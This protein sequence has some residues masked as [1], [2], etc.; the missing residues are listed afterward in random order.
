MNH[1]PDDGGSKHPEASA[2]FYQTT[3]RNTPENCNHFTYKTEIVSLYMC[4]CMFTSSW[5]MDIPICTKLG[6]LIP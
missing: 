1:R 2:N 5:K 4:A 6:M 3:R